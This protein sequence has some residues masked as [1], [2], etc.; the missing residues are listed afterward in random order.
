[1]VAPGTKRPGKWRSGVIQVLI[2]RACNLSCY[3]C[4][5][6]SNLGG[7]PMVM[8]PEQFEVAVQSLKGY[9]GVVGVFGGNP[10]VSPHFNEICKILRK[11]FPKEQC[12]LWCN[13]PMGKG[14]VMRETFNPAVSNLNVH[15]DKGAYAEFKRD[16]PES[17][18]FGLTQD[19]RHSPVFVAMKDVIKDEG[20]RWQLISNCDINVHWSA[21]VGTFRGE[22][23]AWFCEVAGAQAMLHQD[24]PNYPDTGI[25]PRHGYCI[26]S[27]RAEG[28]MVLKEPFGVGVKWWELPM[29]AF[30]HQVR[31]HCHECSVPLKGYGELAQQGTGPEQVSATHADIYKPK[32]K[33]R[34]VQIVTTLEELKSNAIGRFTDYLGNAKRK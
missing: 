12:G 34:Q 26:P 32:R 6:G 8:T 21:I 1:M 5:Q 20:L 7:K 30:K 27:A 10:A 14:K 4:T 33:D 18:P 15:L 2:T 11:Y 16:W 23:R 25:D 31:K 22:V 3:H 24:D 29:H 13:N 17:M 28:L 9:W 19:S